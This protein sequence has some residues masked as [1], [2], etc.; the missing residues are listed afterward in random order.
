MDESIF[1]V[2]KPKPRIVGTG[3]IALD[4]I[5]EPARSTEMKLAAG[6]S[7]GNVLAI[8]SFLGW[9]AYP[10]SRMNGDTASQLIHDDLKRWGVRF[11]FSRLEPHADTPIVVQRNRLNRHGQRKHSFSLRCPKCE[12]WLPMYRPVTA[13]AVHNIK[14]KIVNPAVL[15]MDRVS[16]GVLEIARLCR[17][18]GAVVFFE[19]ASARD[20]S[21][22]SEALELAHIVKFAHDRLDASDVKTKSGSRAGLIIQT[23]GARGLRYLNRLDSPDRIRWRHLDG[24]ALNITG[25]TS[26]AGDWCSAGIMHSLAQGGADSFLQSSPDR[27]RAALA[28]GQS[29]AAW[30][31]G[32]VGARGA[33]YDGPKSKL[34][35]G[36]V[37]MLDG[38]H[39]PHIKQRD[40]RVVVNAR[41]NVCPACRD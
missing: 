21:L 12:R 19:P 8:L 9:A 16:R 3:L 15:Y 13:R 11:N 1:S 20:P 31:C 7:C 17:A 18:K 6:G 22:F 24:H 26:G 2:V 36:I 23:L 41:H 37:G 32:Y 10:V 28:L 14:S 4:I 5:T 30:N 38:K 35:A 34:L 25:D 27:V 33:M 29:L 40:D 39:N